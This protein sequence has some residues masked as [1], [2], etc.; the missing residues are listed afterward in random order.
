MPNRLY[1]FFR[2]AIRVWAIA[3]VFAGSVSA[4]EYYVT[5]SGAGAANGVNWHN[6]ISNIQAAIDL[7]TTD[8]DTIYMQ[9]GAWSN[10]VTLVVSNKPG[11]N[12]RG[13]CNGLA[14]GSSNEYSGTNS[15]L[16]RT[17]GE[18]RIV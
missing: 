6:A 10:A 16:T 14:G 4:T 18:I 2:I 7:A 3:Y 1:L 17:G 9:Y 12:F 5:P 13:G 11:V 8:G 15:T